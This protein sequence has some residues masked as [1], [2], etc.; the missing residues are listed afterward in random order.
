MYKW[1]E[2]KYK[3]LTTYIG[4]FVTHTSNEVTFSP[5]IPS[6]LCDAAT[7]LYGGSGGVQNIP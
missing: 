2:I 4:G 6:C 3:V 7:Y 5:A 1:N